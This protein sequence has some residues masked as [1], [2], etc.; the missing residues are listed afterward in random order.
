MVCPH[1]CIRPFLAK[2][3]DLAGAD[4]SFVTKDARGK[5]VAGYKF[6]M[7]I[8]PLDCT[9]CNNCV[10]ICPAKEKALVMESLDSSLEKQAANWEFAVKLPTPEINFNKKTVI[11]Q[12]VLPAA[13]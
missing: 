8:S 6:R 7:Q 12:P 4:A 1:A 13:V 5:D 9:G 10:D 3:E 11:G 2:E